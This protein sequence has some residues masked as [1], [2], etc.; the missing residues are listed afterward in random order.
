MYYVKVKDA[1]PCQA[2]KTRRHA[3][4]KAHWEKLHLEVEC[5]LSGADDEYLLL[6]ACDENIVL[7]E[8]EKLALHA[9]N[10][11]THIMLDQV[12]KSLWV[13]LQTISVG[14]LRLLAFL[15]TSTWL[16]I[17]IYYTVYQYYQGSTQSFVSN[18]LSA[19]EC[20]VIRKQVNAQQFVS[21][22]DGRGHWSS[23]PAYTDN[24]T[25]YRYAAKASRWRSSS[26][27]CSSY[28]SYPQPA[29]SQRSPLQLPSHR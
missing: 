20:S 21:L 11:F 23:D 1:S 26:R 3:G 10:Y 9:S 25:I 7:T 29:S 5:N 24:S 12:S 15:E 27:W 13:N 8:I 16:S 2:T 28:L 18:E 19:G 22:D 4:E 6:T 17:A 14:M